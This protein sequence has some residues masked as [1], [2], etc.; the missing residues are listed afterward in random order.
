M[1]FCPQCGATFEQGARFCQECGFDAH[2]IEPEIQETTAQTSPGE[3]KLPEVEASPVKKCRQ[4]GSPMN[5]EDRF[6]EQCGTDNALPA[7]EPAITAVVPEPE[8]PVETVNDPVPSTQQPS[9]DGGGFCEEC[10]S[11]MEAGSNFCEQCGADKTQSIAEPVVPEPEPP[12]AV[13]TEPAP[14]NQPPLTNTGGFCEECGSPMTEGSIFCE[15]CGHRNGGETTTAP[16]LVPEQKAAFTTPPVAPPPPP[17]AQRRSEKPAQVKPEIPVQQADNKRKKGILFPLLI[18]A[19]V[20]VLGAGGWFAWDKFLNKPDEPVADTTAVAVVPETEIADDFVQEDT[21]QQT[22]VP[23]AQ[24]EVTTPVKESAKP[25]AGKQNTQKKTPPAKKATE[26]KKTEPTPQEPAQTNEPLKVKIKPSGT[27]TGRTIL[28]IHNNDEAKSGPL[29]A[30]KLKLDKAFVITKIT[31]Y[32]HNWGK[33]AQPGTISL[34][35][36]K[37]TFGPWQARGVAGDDGTPNGKW[38]CEPNVRLEEGTYKVGVSDEKSWSY[39]GQSGQKGF[40]VIEG[41]EAD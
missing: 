10:G 16:P 17:T 14:V 20:L 22:E 29:F 39:N 18:V 32:H 19:G 28:S 27:K 41:Y 6:C 40:V 15:Q 5:P 24:P 37:E 23:V 9:A 1:K 2:S 7:T 4:C 26:P 3:N 35:R 21:V 11:P 36:K 13:V 8:P 12:A 30:S 33:G 38:I 31:T 25:A 34:Q